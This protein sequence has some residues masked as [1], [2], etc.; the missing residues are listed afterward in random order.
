MVPPE[1]TSGPKRRRN[2]IVRRRRMM[3]QRLL[4]G[5][6]FTLLI[7]LFVHSVLLAHL[8]LDMA[9]VGYVAQLRRWRLD[10]RRQRRRAQGL[11][12]AAP[13]RISVSL[14]EP[15]PES[16]RVIALEEPERRIFLD[17]DPFD[18]IAVSFR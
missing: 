8:V 17:E 6:G 2:R 12:A 16:A 14:N 13:G 3:F 1:P 11:T 5:A 10:E 4:L 7:G 15:E 18:R 9:I